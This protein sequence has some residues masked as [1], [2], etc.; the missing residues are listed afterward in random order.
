M[1]K[2]ECIIIHHYAT[3]K[4]NAEIF[5]RAHKKRGWRE[6]GYHYIIGNGTNSGDG[7]AEV[8]RGE[9]ETGAHTVDYNNKSIGICLVGNF[10]EQVPTEKQLKT[11]LALCRDIMGRYSIPAEKVL[12][13]R[14]VSN[15]LCPGKN[16][17]LEKFRAGLLRDYIGHWA[18]S[19]IKRAI[20]AKV[21]SGYPDGS[22]KPEQPI[23]RAELAV[24]LDRL[25]V[26]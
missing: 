14:E 4:G 15:T 12:G 9:S 11:L 3:S 22:W 19:S 26:L 24:I 13:H 2:P 7:E 17:D 10:E 1:N 8:G 25:G 16:F 20:A 5:R 23:T 18:E 21:M 6:V